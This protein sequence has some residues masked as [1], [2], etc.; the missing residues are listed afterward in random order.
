MGAH[1]RVPVERED[2]R[3]CGVGRAPRVAAMGARE[4]LPVGRGYTQICESLG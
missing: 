2:V 4:R 1:E 3:V